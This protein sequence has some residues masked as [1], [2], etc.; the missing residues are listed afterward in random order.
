[1]SPEKWTR[2][3]TVR[4]GLFWWWMRRKEAHIA[5]RDRYR[6]IIQ[7]ACN[8]GL[9]QQSNNRE[10]KNRLIHREG[11]AVPQISKGIFACVTLTLSKLLYAI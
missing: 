8:F 11:F 10:A 9:N 1:M 6:N 5:V 7:F 4:L 2:D 3:R